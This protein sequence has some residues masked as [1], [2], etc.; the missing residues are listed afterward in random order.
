MI[1]DINISSY[2]VKQGEDHPYEEEIGVSARNNPNHNGM[3]IL[4]IEGNTYFFSKKELKK[5]IEVLDM[6]D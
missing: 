3:M 4:E 1:L 6:E 5:A 2:I